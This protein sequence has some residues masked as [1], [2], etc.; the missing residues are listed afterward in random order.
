MLVDR[1]SASASEIFAAAI[2]DYDR[3]VI[4]GQQTFG[5]GSVQNL[6]PLDRF[7][8]GT[9]NGQLTLTIGK[10]Y[11]VT[12]ES[13]QHRGVIP[14]IEL[15]SMVDTETVG[16]STRDTALPWDRIQPTRFR[17]D[18]ALTAE[19]D[20]LRAHQQTRAANDPEFSYLLSDIAAVKEIAAQKSVSLNLDGRIAENKRVEE[21]RLTRE[22][23]RRAALG[24]EP[25]ASI[26]RARQ[27]PRDVGRDPAAPSALEIVAEIAGDGEDRRRSAQR[28][29]AKRSQ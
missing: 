24:L 11:R 25:L 12:G 16:E 3:G 2:Q 10:Y 4:V 26:E 15:P 6:F 27:K 22:N 21:G 18:T 1:Y 8:R 28:I 14:D 19:I 29:T 7:M 9:D 20:D 5:K 23:A 13:T 17:A